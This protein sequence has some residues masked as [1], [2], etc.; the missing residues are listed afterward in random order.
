M[1]KSELRCGRPVV[2][3]R[4]FHR[5]MSGLSG[6]ISSALPSRGLAVVKLDAGQG[7]DGKRYAAYAGSLELA[8]VRA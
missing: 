3:A 4:V 2:L 1:K 6:T 5:E 8:E 7:H